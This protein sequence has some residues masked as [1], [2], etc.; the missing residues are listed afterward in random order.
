MA[1]SFLTISDIIEICG[2]AVSL[3]T[4]IVAIIISVKTLKQNSKMIEESTRPYI[5]IY[6]QTTTVRTP[7]AY[8][9][10]KNFGN[11]G[12]TISS[13]TCDYDLKKCS[14][15]QDG[16]LSYVVGKIKNNTN[17]T[18]SYVQVSINLYKGESQAGSTLANVNNLE[19]GGTWEFKAMVTN[20]DAT[21]Y[22]IVDVTGF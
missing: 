7:R 1:S 19:P 5:T 3:I 8:F 20:T 16:Y 15:V 6:F 14:V 21:S 22:K 11:T 10:I 9:V 18:Y 17:R 13:I 4:G 2:I 12:A